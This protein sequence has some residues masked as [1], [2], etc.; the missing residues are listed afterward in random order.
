MDKIL[1]ALKSLTLSLLLVSGALAA[2]AQVPSIN[3][4]TFAQHDPKRKV[5]FTIVLEE[6]GAAGAVDWSMKGEA[7]YAL[8]PSWDG[9]RGVDPGLNLSPGMKG[10]LG[11]QTAATSED[12]FELRGGFLGLKKGER[13]QFYRKESTDQGRGRLGTQN[14]SWS[15]RKKDGVS[16]GTDHANETEATADLMDASLV[17]TETGARIQFNWWISPGGDAGGGVGGGASSWGFSDAEA[18]RILTFNLTNDDLRHWDRIHKANQGKVVNKDD[19]AVAADVTAW[20]TTALAPEDEGEATVEIE[21]YEDWIPEGNI[22]DPERAGNTLQIKVKAHKKEKPNQPLDKKVNFTFT[23]E[24]VSMEPGV[25]MNW[26]PKTNSNYGLRILEDRNPELEVLGPDSARNR[27]AGEKASLTVS[28]FSYGAWGRLKVQAVTEDGASLKVCFQEKEI[29]TIPLPYY[30]HNDHI[31]VAWLKQHGMVGKPADWDGETDP[32]G[33]KGA[34][35][36][37]TLYEEYRGFAVKG[38]HVMGHPTK[39]DIFIC[40]ETEQE[41]QGIDLFERITDLVVHRVT[42]EELG[43]GRVI[44]RNHSQTPHGVDQ[45]GLLIVRGTGSPEAV[46]VKANTEPGPP[47]TCRYV[48]V[49]SPSAGASPEDKADRASLVAHEICHGVGVYHHGDLEGAR[50]WYWKKDDAGEW[51]LYEDDLIGDPDTPAGELKLANKPRLIRAIREANGT[52]L[53]A[54]NSMPTG[55]EWD[56]RLNGYKL[57]IFDKQSQCSGDTACVMRYVDR[58]AWVS[59]KDRS[60]R[61]IPDRKQKVSQDSLCTSAEGTGVN[62]RQHSPESRYGDAQRGRGNCKDQII[63]NDKSGAR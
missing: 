60:V 57:L 44:N 34:G 11:L 12:L 13:L 19:P 18:A 14:L 1:R 24:G 15:N 4:R 10:G 42:L 55:S 49:P 58:Q 47:R 61:Y 37:L 54:G 43:V 46:G 33:S 30:E 27:R 23:L 40:D 63:V 41:A 26:P 39:K 3:L 48:K 17:R 56:E 20:L 7:R 2:F 29:D 50:L 28:T 38:K 51:V 16:T 52:E 6:H 5:Y 25:C 9:A 31:A 22:G 45:H 32:P 62:G 59:S 8:L 21:G 53:K 35:D 36:G